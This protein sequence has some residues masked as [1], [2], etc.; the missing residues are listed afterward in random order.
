VPP[1]RS[2]VTRRL[3]IDRNPFYATA[4]RQLFLAWLGRAVVG[5]VAAIIDDAR[6]AEIAEAVGY[7]GFFEAIDS[8]EIV[9]ALLESASQWLTAAGAATIRGPINGSS[10]DEMG[11]LIEGFGTRPALWQGHHP[12]YYRQRLEELPLT[13]FDDVLAFEMTSADIGGTVENLPDF[14]AAAADRARSAGLTVRSPTRDSWADDVVIAHRLY[15]LSHRT[16]TGHGTMSLA[17][18]SSLADS[19]RRVVD[20]DLTLLAELRGEPIGFAIAVPDVNEALAKRAFIRRPWGS[21]ALLRALRG[22]NTA[23]VKLVGVLPE[24]RGRG[25]GSLL[26]RELASRLIRKG[27]QRC[28]MSLVSERNV[29]MTSLLSGLGA[30][31]YRRYRVYEAALPLRR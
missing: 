24:H 23:S 13:R 11:L 16:I 6:N 10:S 1:I 4:R 9:E 3:D 28:E 29:A 7:F 19:L 26:C 30:R 5:T 20:L 15:A 14:L 8:V 25:T 21:P 22:V 27:Y 2:Q 17:Q 12:P 31:V 18:F